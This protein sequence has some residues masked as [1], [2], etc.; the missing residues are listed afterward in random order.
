MC[1]QRWRRRQKARAGQVMRVFLS[2]FLFCSS[3]SH[4]V[5]FL[6]GRRQRAAP[7][8]QSSCAMRRQTEDADALLRL[9][10]QGRPCPTSDVRS[11]APP[12]KTLQRQNGGSRGACVPT[13]GCAVA[14]ARGEVPF[15]SRKSPR[16][17][18]ERSLPCVR[19]APRGLAHSPRALDSTS[20]RARGDRSGGAAGALVGADGLRRR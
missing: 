14:G 15:F 11:V 10:S 12:R 4:S 18:H 19:R 13:G 2:S 20:T 9:T 3:E 5:P 17:G 1:A 6:L 7:G 8:R 16:R